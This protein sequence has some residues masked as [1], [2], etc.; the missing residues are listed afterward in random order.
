MAAIKEGSQLKGELQSY[1]AVGPLGQD[2]V[3]TAVGDDGKVFVVKAPT[4]NDNPAASYPHFCHEMI[5]H[6]LFKSSNGIRKQVDRIP[7]VINSGA[8]PMLVLEIFETTLWQARSKRPFSKD[9]IRAVCCGILH[10]LQQVH[11]KGLVYADLKMPNVMLNGFNVGAP[12]DGSGL[13]AKLGDLGIVMPPCN[14]KVQ[15]VAYRAPEIYFKGE[16]APPAD[17]WAFGLVCC[18]L[19]E[20]RNRFSNTGL[21]DDLDTGGGSMPEREQAVRYAIADDYDIK[22]VD[23]YKGCALPY[24]HANHPKGHQW[25]EL[26]KRGLDE[27]DVEFLQW[28]LQPDP[29]KRPTA[30]AILKSNWINTGTDSSSFSD[31]GAVDGTAEVKGA[32]PVMSTKAPSPMQS[33]APLRQLIEATTH[34]SNPTA[35]IAVSSNT[36]ST[37]SLSSKTYQPASSSTKFT[38]PPAS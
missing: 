21:Y 19:L 17:I 4:A 11:E 33:A 24:Q 34:S 10:G 36:T 27:K 29:T 26:R 30:A 18:H 23:Y 5:M 28:V 37:K 20:A 2:N 35:P 32:S 3:W 25:S 13:V 12:G 16:I 8:P 6:E 38:S 14:G 31:I 1:L 7:P 15:P 9:E 22:N